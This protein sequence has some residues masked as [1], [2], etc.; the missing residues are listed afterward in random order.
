MI[1]GALSDGRFLL[2]AKF[3]NAP[4]ASKI[5]DVNKQEGFEEK[6]S[7]TDP[8]ADSCNHHHGDKDLVNASCDIFFLPLD[9]T[10]YCPKM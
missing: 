5:V 6:F 7:V 10:I 1:K 8:H 3:S 9:I 4:N 2:L